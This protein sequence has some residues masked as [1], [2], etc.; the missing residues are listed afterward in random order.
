MIVISMKPEKEMVLLFKLYN[1]PFTKGIFHKQL[2]CKKDFERY[3]NAP[4][5]DSDFMNWLNGLISEGCLEKG[6]MMFK[7]RNGQKGSRAFLYSVNKKKIIK[8]LEENS[9]Y[10]IAFKYFEDRSHLG[11]SKS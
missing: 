6:D 3:L 5:N 9:L 2:G 10:H 4:A 8:K 7:Y 11:I 1:S